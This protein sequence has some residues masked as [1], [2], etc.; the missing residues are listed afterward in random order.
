VPLSDDVRARL[1]SQVERLR[2]T[3]PGVA[4]VTPGNLHITLKFLGALAP[5]MIEPVTA[6]LGEVAA[7]LTSFRLTIQGLGAFPSL[8]RPRVIW[9]G[10]GE[11]A[12]TLVALATSIEAA[13]APLGF[14]PEARSFSP[15]VTLGRVRAPRR[16]PALTDALGQGETRAFG[17]V[18][19]DRVS[20]MRSDLS[21]RGA[22]YTELAAYPLGS[23]AQ[24]SLSG[25]HAV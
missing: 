16:D 4:W 21:P 17:V 18:N 15:H 11:G 8:T 7:R 13:L 5:A 1:G 9:A 10:T 23:R 12:P 25:R 14:P 6:G 3:S 22:R 20:L 19:V 24:D 2:L